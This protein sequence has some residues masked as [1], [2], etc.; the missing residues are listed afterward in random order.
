MFKSK[1]EDRLAELEQAVADA[2]KALVDTKAATRTTWD[3]VKDL[4]A[5]L[6]NAPDSPA[7]VAGLSEASGA[8]RGGQGRRRTRP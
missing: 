2:T 1:I 8:H 5:A 4:R 3:K 7:L 6:D